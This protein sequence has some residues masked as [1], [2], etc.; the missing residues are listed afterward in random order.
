M[1]RSCART[2]HL[3]HGE[4]D[5]ELLA[6]LRTERRSHVGEVDLEDVAVEEEDRVERLV[7]RRRGD[8]PLG[9][10][11]AQVGFGILGARNA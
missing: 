7:L 9:G 3:I 8:S 11:L 4:D 1:P 6:P 5:G 10:E 2:A